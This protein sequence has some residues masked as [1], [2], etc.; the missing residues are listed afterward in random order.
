MP[1]HLSTDL[2]EAYCMDT[3]SEPELTKVKEHLWWCQACSDNVEITKRY[4]ETAN[5]M[6]KE[7]LQRGSRSGTKLRVKNMN[8]TAILK[9]INEE[10][11]AV[12]QAI[13]VFERIA[14]G[15]KR[16]RGRPPAWMKRLDEGRM[17]TPRRGRPPKSKE[18]P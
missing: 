4:L 17:D 5:V 9:E 2:I 8:L 12:Q 11:E 10:L 3:I 13:T 7:Q 14:A 1:R 15:T 6:R 16:G 18:T